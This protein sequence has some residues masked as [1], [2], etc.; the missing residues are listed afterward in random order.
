MN[1]RY[2]HEAAAAE[3]D[4]SVDFSPGFDAGTVRAGESGSVGCG[5]AGAGTCVR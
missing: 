1:E 4:R 2:V 3:G 5:W